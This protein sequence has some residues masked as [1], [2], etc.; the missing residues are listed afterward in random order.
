[1]VFER[2]HI[3]CMYLACDVAVEFAAV[4]V[5][6]IGASLSFDMVTSLVVNWQMA[7]D[8][9]VVW[10][11]VEV[12]DCENIEVK[13]VLVAYEVEPSTVFTTPASLLLHEHEGAGTEASMLLCQAIQAAED[14]L[15]SLASKAKDRIETY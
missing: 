1:M 13:T 8:G 14:G 9:T 10:M 7:Y 3:K 15:I 4:E 11:T 12:M 6:V 2:I 5:S